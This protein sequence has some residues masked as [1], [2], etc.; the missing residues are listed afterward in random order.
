VDLPP[1]DYTLLATMPGYEPAVASVTVPAGAPTTC[2]FELSEPPGADVFQNLLVSPGLN[3]AA[4]AWDTTTGTVCRVVYGLSLIALNSATALE[5]GAATTHDALLAGLTANTRYFFRL[6]GWNGTNAYRSAIASFQTGGEL[7]LDNPDAAF[8]GSWATGTSSTDKYGPDYRYAGTVS[9]AAT[10]SANWTPD[11]RTPGRY[12]VYVW[13]P[14]GSNRS[15][16]APFQIHDAGGTP[17]VNVNQTVNGG[18][19]RLIGANRLFALGSGGW[20][21]LSNLTGE[22]G[23]VVIAD[24]VRWQYRAEQDTGT[25]GAVPLWWAQHYFGGPV[26]GSDD[27]DGDDYSNW[28]E[29]LLGTVPTQ[30]ASRLRFWIEPADEDTTQLTFS[31][32]VGGRGYQLETRPVLGSGTWEDLAHAPPAMDTRGYGMITDTNAP[33]GQRFYRLRVVLTP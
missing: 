29:Y 6:E 21:R 22:S 24:A 32:F 3:A 16:A 11:I 12:N 19:W 5:E 14:Q 30:Q 26:N 27:P 8:S 4:L 17:N 18:G 28:A 31:P 20:A 33:A 7:I 1:G 23:K 2:D 25:G 15:T 9:G 13:Y 10:A